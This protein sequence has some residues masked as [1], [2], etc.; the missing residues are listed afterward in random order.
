MTTIEQIEMNE[1]RAQLNA[2]MKNLVEKY[3]SIFGWN[4][5]DI[6]EAESDRLIFQ[7]MRQA[8]T[9]IEGKTANAAPC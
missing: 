4:V 6:D 8:L 5:P 7:A 9:S 3:R 1:Q 2:D